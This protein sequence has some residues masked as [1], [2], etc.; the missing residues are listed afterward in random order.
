RIDDGRL[1]LGQED[2]LGALRVFVGADVKGDALRAAL[3]LEVYGRGPDGAALV[4]SRGASAE[5]VEGAGQE[6]VAGDVVRA[7]RQVHVRLVVE[8]VVVVLGAD[9]RLQVNGAALVGAVGGEDV[10]VEGEA[11]VFLV[12]RAAVAAGA[13]AGEGIVEQG[14]VAAGCSNRAA[15]PRAAVAGEDAVNHRERVAVVY[16]ATAGD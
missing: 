12:E 11:A 9:A 5:M 14:H 4:D 15:V 10:V 16:E 1:R 3:Q 13:V 2:E 8:E 6:R 7:I